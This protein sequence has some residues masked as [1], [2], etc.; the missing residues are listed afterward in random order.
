M[1]M[2]G[3][4]A[5]NL[6]AAVILVRFGRTLIGVWP[7]PAAVPTSYLLLAMAIWIVISGCMSVESCL[8]AALNRAREQA[9]LSIIAAALNIAPSIALVRHIGSL[10][11]IG[12]RFYP[13][14]WC[15]LSRKA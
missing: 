3:T 11:V 5:L 9:V 7:G 15:S 1:M 8:L 10:G 14:C 4:V 13:I 2:K 12:G 6:A